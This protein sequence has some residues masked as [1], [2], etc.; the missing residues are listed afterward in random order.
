[1]GNFSSRY[2]LLLFFIVFLGVSFFT[3]DAATLSLSPSSTST[4]VGSIFSVNILLDTQGTSTNGVD[5]RYLNFP[6][7]TLQV[8]DDGGASGVQITAGALMPQT[9]TNIAD[10][11]LGRVEFLQ[12][13]SLGSGYNGNGTLATV[14]FRALAAGTANVTFNFTSGATTDTNVDAG[15]VDILTSVTNGSYTI[16]AAPD[17]TAPIISNVATSS[18]TQSSVI[19]SWTTNEPATTRIDYGLTSSYGSQTS[20]DS[21]LVI[22]HSQT[23]SGLT[24]NTLYHFRARSADANNNLALSNDYT[25]RTA[26]VADTVPPVLSNGS[27]SGQ[28]SA[29]TT[30]TNLSLTTNEN[31]TCRYSTTAGTA[32]SAMTNFSTTGALNHSTNVSGLTN[33]SSYN[34]YVRCQDFASPPNANTTDFLISFSVASGGG[35]GDTTPPIISNIA[36]SSITSSSAVISWTT[37]ESAT[38]RVNYGLTSSYS[39]QTVLDSNLTTNHSQ[40]ISGLTANTLYHFQALS[41]DATGNSAASSD[42]TFTTLSAPIVDSQAPIIPGNLT[43][44]PISSS[45]IDLSWTASTDNVGVAGYRI[46]RCT[47]SA[48]SPTVQ[49][50]TTTTAASYLNINLNP[51]TPYTY[52][53]SAYDAAGNVSS[54]SA[55]ST[56]TTLSLNTT[57]PELSNGS[58]IG[59][60][61]A[62]TTQTALSLTTNENATCRYSLTAGTLYGAMFDVISTT[63][64][65]NHSVNIL[66]LNDGNNYTYYVA[67]QNTDGYAN[68]S[69]YPISFSVASASTGG[70]STG[71]GGSGGGGGG[72]SVIIPPSGG[73]G[74]GGGITVSN[75]PSGGSLTPVQIRNLVI[76]KLN[77]ILIAEKEAVG[78]TT[79][80]FEAQVFDSSN[81]K[82]RLEV[83]LRKFDEQFTNAPTLFSEYVDSGK[84]AIIAR[85]GL[86]DGSYRLRA[87]ARRYP[88]PNI[89]GA[90]V[91][92][93]WL[94]FGDQNTR[95]FTV[96]ASQQPVQVTAET[97]FKYYF[98]SNMS[99][100]MKNK[101]VEA[102]QK[103]LNLEGV[104]PENIVSGYFGNLTKKAVIAFQ[105]KY[106]ISPAI[107]IAGPLTRTKLNALY[108]PKEGTA[109]VITIT[110]ELVGPFSI[111][112][113]SEQVKILQTLLSKDANIYPEGKITGYYGQLTFEAVKRFQTKY[114]IEQ[115]G[116][117]GPKTRAKINEILGK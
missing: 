110:G 99:L 98:G 115:T 37:N 62:G 83:E 27:P 15:G 69:D 91:V 65:T 113:R 55:V 73:G 74:G 89:V 87:R 60:L 31:A 59:Q 63:P 40:T 68:T 112:M 93:E 42:S 97:G 18:L 6:T 78:E 30:Q 106:S 116:I 70:G 96:L 102:L 109:P 39:S 64:T 3:A 94:W 5:I 35:G 17:T 67:C 104:Y 53:V 25:F 11:S 2:K 13:A 34:Y 84:I 111:G 38:S 14:R 79:L 49:I 1:M 66:G 90:E 21:T 47:G 4:T 20:F 101:D 75:P 88:N 43:A 33:G 58:P 86:V 51:S 117:A 19:V 29:G 114:G 95:D 12:L 41:S 46:Y 71:G 100:G 61:S 22:G 80:N 16:S 81:Q 10:N 32:Y 44:N 103:I 23:I 82:V 108:A 48:C 26:A 8:Q 92:S 28:L 85:G 76:R 57:P 77:G 54:Q 24:A 107:G 105:K 56:A 45:Q 50:A 52:A 9:I 36:V 7:S 72:G